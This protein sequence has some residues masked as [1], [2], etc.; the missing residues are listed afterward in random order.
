MKYSISALVLGFFAALS[1]A[2]PT[3]DEKPDKKD[4][5]ISEVKYGG[6]GCPGGSA[7]VQHS[8]D[9]QTVTVI[10]DEYEASIGP[11]IPFPNKNK[12]CNLN[13]KIN[14][15]QGYQ[16][17]LYKLDYTG[18][19]DLEKGVSAKQESM[20]WFAGIPGRATLRSKFDGPYSKTYTFTDTLATE[21]CVWSPCG[22]STTL[23]VNTLLSLS[24]NNPKSSGAI[25]TQV[26]D[27]TVKNKY[28]AAYGVNWRKCTK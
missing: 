6:T 13:F 2:A 8:Q 1:V 25:S 24:S 22:A 27:A 9:L 18:Y 14:Y 7:A 12:N 23:N 3:P 10:F 11:G 4:V 20:Y 16:Y 17:T 26:I 28:Y 21:M 19:A 5:T 15:P